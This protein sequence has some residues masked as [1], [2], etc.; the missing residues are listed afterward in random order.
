MKGK[1]VDMEEFEKTIKWKNR[2]RKKQNEACGGFGNMYKRGAGVKIH[3]RS[4]KG[5]LESK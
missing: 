1:E 5:K 3:R 2:Q 4:C